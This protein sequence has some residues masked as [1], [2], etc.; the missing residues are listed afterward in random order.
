MSCTNGPT[1]SKLIEG[2]AIA[3][4]LAVPAVH[5]EHKRL[6]RLIA[7]SPTGMRKAVTVHRL[8]GPPRKRVEPFKGS[9]CVQVADESR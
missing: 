6:S 2:S 7:I 9:A 5:V 1:A 3:H 8:N 4:D